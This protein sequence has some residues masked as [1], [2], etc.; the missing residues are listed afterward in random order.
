MTQ[1]DILTDASDWNKDDFKTNGLNLKTGCAVTNTNFT[2]TGA[3]Y[4]D[5]VTS[6][7]SWVT[8]NSEAEISH[9]TIEISEAEN[10]EILA[11]ANYKIIS[12]QVN[13]QAN[14]D[15]L[16]LKSSGGVLVSEG[17]KLGI[18]KQAVIV[19][20]T[21]TIPGEISIELI[22]YDKSAGTVITWRDLTANTVMEHEFFAQKHFIVLDELI[23]GHQY[24]ITAAHK[25]TVRKVIFSNPV[26][27]YVQ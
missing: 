26:K 25:G 16:K 6:Y 10:L 5:F 1:P 15:I 4:T 21:A 7:D 11:K 2:F 23:S 18:L 9:D 22:I 27:V 24:E 3:T 19:G 13:T 8:K 14:H 12:K 20:I 17:G